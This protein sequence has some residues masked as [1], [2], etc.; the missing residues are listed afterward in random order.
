[1][2]YTLLYYYAYLYIPNYGTIYTP[3]MTSFR[4]VQ[5]MYMALR[6]LEETLQQN[7]HY[8]QTLNVWNDDLREVMIMYVRFQTLR[9]NVHSHALNLNNQYLTLL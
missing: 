3:Y 1:M 9:V 8:V 4:I 7:L 5:L 6:W 2:P